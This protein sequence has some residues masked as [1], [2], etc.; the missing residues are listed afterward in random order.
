MIG[1]G[2][3][4]CPIRV[5]GAA[6]DRDYVWT[7][8][9]EETVT[10]DAA[11]PGWPI[12]MAPVYAGAIAG[13]VQRRDVPKQPVPNQAVPFTLKVTSERSGKVGLFV[14]VFG[15]ARP[16]RGQQVD[17]DDILP[18]P[19]SPAWTSCG[20]VM[21]EGEDSN[22]VPGLGD[23]F[24]TETNP[25]EIGRDANARLTACLS[26]LFGPDGAFGGDTTW[27]KPWTWG[28]AVLAALDPRSYLLI[29]KCLGEYFFVP[30]GSLSTYAARWFADFP[31]SGVFGLA[32]GFSTLRGIYSGFGSAPDGCSAPSF[33]F[34]VGQSA[35][36][37]TLD[38]GEL[39]GQRFAAVRVFTRTT[40]ALSLT[41]GSAFLVVRVA[42]WALGLRKPPVGDEQLSFKGM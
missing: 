17:L 2:S 35:G 22:F 42:F 5:T 18:A 13:D 8:G 7:A 39:C 37:S 1:G 27:W 25:G 3:G 28:D 33:S 36:P 16:G 23:S 9:Q 31:D 10:V 20:E 14:R 38:L 12:L 30:T 26:G 40:S 34:T 19:G 24:S 32:R 41:L 11:N 29:T 4:S 15:W 6:A 21:F